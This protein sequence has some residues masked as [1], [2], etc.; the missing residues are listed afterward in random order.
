[1]AAGTICGTLIFKLP[2][3]DIMMAIF[4]MLRKTGKLLGY[5]TGIILPEMT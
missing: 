5:L 1:M 4:T 3:M 2:L